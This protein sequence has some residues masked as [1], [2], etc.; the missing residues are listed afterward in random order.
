MAI[1]LI[2]VKCPECNAVLD[3]EENRKQA[4]CTYCGTKILINNENEYT[5]RHIDEAGIK[6]A[7]TERIIKLKKMELAENKRRAEERTKMLKIIISLILATVG[8]VMMIVGYIAGDATGDSDSGFYMLSMVGMFP[9]M[10]AA[11][12][13]LFS[14]NK[15][16]EVGFEGMIRVPASIAGYENKSYNAIEAILTSAGFTNVK[17]VALNDLT[18]GVLKKPGMVESITI[19]GNVITAGGKKY[20]PDSDVVIAYHSFSGRT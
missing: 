13:W 19:N 12:I 18:F 16:A 15:D 11:Y 10:G 7:E 14:N 4:F 1:K 20:L 3:L 6:R 2:S 17:C 5:Y 8:I 9:L